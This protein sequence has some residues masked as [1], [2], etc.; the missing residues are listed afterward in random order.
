ML[1]ENPMGRETLVG[2]ASIRK[3]EFALQ[4]PIGE[5]YVVPYRG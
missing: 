4:C 2:N 1:D 3:R 5:V